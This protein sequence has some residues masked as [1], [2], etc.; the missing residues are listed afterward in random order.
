MALSIFTVG[1]E[2]GLDEVD[3]PDYIYDPEYSHLLPVIL[4]LHSFP[5]LSIFLSIKLSILIVSS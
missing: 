3:D 1:D 5:T 2:F 4:F